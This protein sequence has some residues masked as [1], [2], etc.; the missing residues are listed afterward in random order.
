MELAKHDEVL[1]R[2]MTAYMVTVELIKKASTDKPDLLS[3][4]RASILVAA[5]QSTK[6]ATWVSI[7]F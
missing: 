4:L 3:S 1:R 6:S 5:F 7:I 2:L